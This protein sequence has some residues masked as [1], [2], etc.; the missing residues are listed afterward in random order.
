V[1]GPN[2]YEL[3]ITGPAERQLAKLPVKVATAVVEFIVGP[4]LENPHRLG[5]V[6]HRELA[7][8]RS[9][10]RGAYRVVYEIDA[11]VGAVIVHRID[12]RAD[13]YRPK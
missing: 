10:R 13:V 6:L 11:G 9:A 8:F 3:R 4:L 1:T 7:G 12:H 5:G 2:G